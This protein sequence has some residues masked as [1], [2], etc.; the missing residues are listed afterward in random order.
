MN[1]TKARVTNKLVN[2]I[3]SACQKMSQT[4]VAF[5]C[6]AMHPMV[7]DRPLHWHCQSGILLCWM[8]TWVAAQLIRQAAVCTEQQRWGL[9]RAC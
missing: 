1:T 9:G 2:A 3:K 8:E 5:G 4:K 6:K 7:C